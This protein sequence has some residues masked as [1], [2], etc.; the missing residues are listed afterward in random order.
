MSIKTMPP[1]AQ[2]PG[3]TLDHGLARQPILGQDEKVIGYEL[4]FHAGP[5][6][7]DFRADKDRGTGNTIDTLNVVGLDAICDGRLA[8]INCSHQMLLNEYFLLLPSDRVVVEIQET[9]PADEAVIAACQGLKDRGYKIALDNFAAD[10]PRNALVPLADFIKVDI[11]RFT[12]AQHKSI[13]AQ[14][15]VSHCRKIAQRVDTREQHVFAVK[16]GFNLFQGYFFHQPERMRARHIPA[17]QSNNLRL[18][19]AISAP[20]VDLEVVENLI[21]HDAS[22]CYR[23]LRYLNSP[24]MGIA[25]PVH[26]V[27]H[28]MNM[29]GERE[30]V[31]WIRMATTLI[32]G[33]DKCSDL[34]LSSLVR[35]RFCELLAP[36]LGPTRSDLFLM[37]M[38][39]LMDAILEIP[40]G[41][42]VEGLAVDAD[43]KAELL[44]ARTGNET[45][46]SPVYRLMVAREAGNWE[47]VAAETKKFN[48]L[49]IASVNRAYN[50]AMAWAREMTA[51]KV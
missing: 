7:T 5:L 35:A 1:V 40:M 36:K 11:R 25:S 6:D 12:P 29:L 14:P 26:S 17:T 32:M 18:L 30:L 44:S 45:P 16:A 10:D 8:F 27:R 48:K 42:V 46:L 21:K 13:T 47:Q 20:E 41:V 31:R 34:V 37:G 51:G 19:Q 39:S 24:V 15:A 2:A 38:L 49:S 9:V 50:E 43:T 3:K 28:A 33:E 22:V 23:L 4:L